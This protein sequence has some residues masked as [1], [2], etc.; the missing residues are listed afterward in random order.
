MIQSKRRSLEEASVNMVAGFIV[1]MML[2][3]FVLPPLLGISFSD[4][5]FE[6]S[7]YISMIYGLTSLVRSFILRRMYNSSRWRLWRRKL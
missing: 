7:I 1:G 3:I 4:L 5:G 2:N 6:I